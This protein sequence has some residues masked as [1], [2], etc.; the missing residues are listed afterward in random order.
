MKVR[1]NR[2]E[3]FFDGGDNVK[4][5]RE[6]S[7]MTMAFVAMQRDAPCVSPVINDITMN[8][9]QNNGFTVLF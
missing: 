7:L 3:S 4:G 2:G 1:S 6:A 8:Q 9:S 5:K